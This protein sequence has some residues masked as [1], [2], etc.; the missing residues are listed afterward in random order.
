MKT[1]HQYRLSQRGKCVYGAQSWKEKRLFCK[2]MVVQIDRGTLILKM[3]EREVFPM[4]P[5]DQ[6][7]LS[8][9]GEFAYGA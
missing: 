5:K 6:Y 9:W 1:K 3:V 4:E 2:S 8:Q 7:H